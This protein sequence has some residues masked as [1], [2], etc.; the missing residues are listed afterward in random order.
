MAEALK[1]GLTKNPV[2]NN[3]PRDMLYARALSRLARQ[4]FPDLIGNCYV[5]GEISEDPNI[6]EVAEPAQIEAPVKK[7]ERLSEDQH[8]NLSFFLDQ[9]PEYRDKVMAFLQKKGVSNLWEMPQKTY[10][11]VLE[12]AQG[13][14]QNQDQTDGGI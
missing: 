1:A 9:V 2:W 5:K 6:P 10:E 4:L 14:V 8:K 12:K 3:F 11:V 7:S 13:H